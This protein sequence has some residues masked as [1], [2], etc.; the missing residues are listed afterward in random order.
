MTCIMRESTKISCYDS[1]QGGKVNSPQSFIITFSYTLSKQLLRLY[2]SLIITQLS[3][4]TFQPLTSIYRRCNFVCYYWG[5]VIIYR[6]LSYPF[7]HLPQF[8]NRR[9]HPFQPFQTSRALKN[10][11]KNKSWIL[12]NSVNTRVGPDTFLPDTGYPAD[13]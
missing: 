12:K 5:C 13:L 9:I 8:H 7:N 4:Q 6:P 10:T 1:F 2:W 11:D 3:V